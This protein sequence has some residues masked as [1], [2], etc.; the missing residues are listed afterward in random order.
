MDNTTITKPQTNSKEEQTLITDKNEE[1]NKSNKRNKSN[2]S[3]QKATDEFGK[4]DINTD[5]SQKD[6]NDIFLEINRA[7]VFINGEVNYII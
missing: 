4:L 5:M 7:E 2:K 1:S 3:K 6:T